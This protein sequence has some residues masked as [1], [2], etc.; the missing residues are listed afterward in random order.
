M[1]YKTL[2]ISQTQPITHGSKQLPTAFIIVMNHHLDISVDLEPSVAH[3][4]LYWSE[5]VRQDP[6]LFRR[7][8]LNSI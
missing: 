3:A 6:H 2:F 4:N 8:F 7:T 1:L 5:C